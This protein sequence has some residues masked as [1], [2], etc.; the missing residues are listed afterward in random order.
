MARRNPTSTDTTQL[1]Y[2][3]M[4][5]TTSTT[6]SLVSAFSAANFSD[7]PQTFSSLLSLQSLQKVFDHTSSVG[8]TPQSLSISSAPKYFHNSGNRLD[9]SMQVLHS[10]FIRSITIASCCCVYVLFQ[11]LPEYCLNTCF[12]STTQVSINILYSESPFPTL[13]VAK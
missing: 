8:R 5:Q 9:I 10:Y 3:W 11:N 1:M 13:C 6:S 2:W 12:T 4:L 7:S